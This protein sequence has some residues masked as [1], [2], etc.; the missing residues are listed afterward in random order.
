MHGAVVLYATQIEGI[1]V[2]EHGPKGRKYAYPIEKY[3]SSILV[4]LLKK[5]LCV[6][7]LDAVT[8]GISDIRNEIAHVGKP[9][10][11]L[12]KLS[13]SDLSDIA[14][15]LELIVVG[16]VLRKLGVAAPVV[17]QYQEGFAPPDDDG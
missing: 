9:A 12:K 17:M 16:Y 14:L 4:E 10:K 11:L 13:N 6:T 8:E 15:C 1:H 7:T 5:R 2:E 3:A